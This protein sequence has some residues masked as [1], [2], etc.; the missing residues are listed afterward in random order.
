MIDVW[1]S[2]E[3]TTKRAVRHLKF[4]RSDMFN[5]HRMEGGKKKESAAFLDAVAKLPKVTVS[6]VKSV[7]PHRTRL[8]LDGF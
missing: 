4:I 1:L 7:H 3:T 5:I 6:F 2:K 8:A